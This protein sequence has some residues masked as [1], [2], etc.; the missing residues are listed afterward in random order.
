MTTINQHQMKIILLLLGYIFSECEEN[1]SNDYKDYNMCRETKS[2]RS[3]K[4]SRPQYCLSKSHFS[5]DESNVRII[6]AGQPTTMDYVDDRCTVY[7]D[8]DYKITRVKCG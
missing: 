1:C 7:V 6:E 3:R 2:R 5:E 4:R 8:D